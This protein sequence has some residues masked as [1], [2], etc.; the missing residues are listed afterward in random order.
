MNPP[1]RILFPFV[2]DTVGGSHLSALCL[3][4]G[5]DRQLFE[6]IVSVHR[7]GPLANY[8]AARGATYARPPNVDVVRAGPFYRRA[9]DV[10]RC[11]GALSA[12][13]HAQRIC[14]VHA[15]DMRMHLTWGLAA[16]LAGARFIWHRRTT[17][18]LGT[19]AIFAGLASEIVA[20]SECCRQSLGGSARRR[21]RLI[22]NPIYDGGPPL[23]RSAARA[24]ISEGLSTDGGTYFVSFIGNLTN[25]KRPL[26]F[27]EAAALLRDHFGDRIRC[28]MFGEE[29]PPVCE[30]VRSRIRELGLEQSCILM[31]PRFPI[32]PWLAGCDLLLAPAVNEGF[33][34]TLVEAMLVGTPVVASAAAG[35]LEI[36]EDG[37]TGI[38]TSPED[39]TS[40]AK[41]AIQLLC[42]P[43][44]ARTLAATA[45][46]LAMQ[47][48]SVQGHVAAVQALYRELLR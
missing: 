1:F 38:L 43:A 48:Y 40:L 3:I 21:A 44:R 14:V 30:A 4:E 42:D 28:L 15:N 34:R 10:L 8:L 47:R 2:G 18:P 20:I 31:G 45:R 22:P 17:G 35:H 7:D 27:V 9:F 16:Q 46:P 29:R 11:A 25:Q 39:P 37:S 36:I 19:N 41:A 26:V 33:G 24:V 23:D 12:F 5:L 13:L 6:P 32:E